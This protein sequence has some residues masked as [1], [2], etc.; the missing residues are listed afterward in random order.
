[1]NHQAVELSLVILPRL[2]AL[3]RTRLPCLSL[4]V[5]RC[6]RPLVPCTSR[7]RG[8]GVRRRAAT[9]PFQHSRKLD[10]ALDWRQDPGGPTFTDASALC[11]GTQG[12]ILLIGV[13]C[14]AAAIPLS[15]LSLAG[16]ACTLRI[17]TRCFLC[18]RRRVCPSVAS[19]LSQH[20]TPQRSMAARESHADA[21]AGPS[22]LRL[23]QL[24][25]EA[26]A[27]EL[28]PCLSTQAQRR[29]ARWGSAASPTMC[30]AGSVQVLQA[31]AVHLAQPGGF[32]QAFLLPTVCR[33]AVS[34]DQQRGKPEACGIC[35]WR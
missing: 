20:R 1:L 15:S 19:K 31:C 5:N 10:A 11:L 17:N 12:H 32:T 27:G 33:C 24:P 2:Q 26:R 13:L 22:A 21:A 28:A 25:A 8:G 18:H 34:A 7:C 35:A 3:L 30:A 16:K 9:E 14:A 29:S 23:D 4:Q 6:D